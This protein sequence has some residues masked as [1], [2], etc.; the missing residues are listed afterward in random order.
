V[1]YLDKEIKLK[2][3]AYHH[4][5]DQMKIK[6]D[7]TE[8][9]I[10]EF[11]KS[12]RYLN[13]AKDDFL[14]ANATKKIIEDMKIRAS[15]GLPADFA[16]LYHW[17]IIHSYYAMYHAATAAIAKKKIKTSSHVAT[18]VSLAKHYATDEVL[19]FDFIKAIE[20]TY[21]TYIESGRK[22]RQGAQYNVDKMYSMEEAYEVFD[23]TKKFVKK[24]QGLL[25]E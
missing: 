4:A 18:I 21:I 8:G 17:L 16:N 3:K 24:I 12:G 5:Y 20:Y 11:T 1:I 25:E 23:N 9:D 13:R 6:G 19:E 15:L 14:L 22:S 10:K 2:I 7:I